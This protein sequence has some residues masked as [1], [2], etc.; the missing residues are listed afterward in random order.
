MSAAIA[1]SDQ[2]ITRVITRVITDAR[3]VAARA[4]VPR[5]THAL[6]L[7]LRVLR[8]PSGVTARTEIRENV[9][10]AHVLAAVPVRVDRNRSHEPT[11][12]HMK[13]TQMT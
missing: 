10:I 3:V 5:S 9:A 2:R 1:P 8:A 12:V 13:N 7:R 6:A 11:A 4:V